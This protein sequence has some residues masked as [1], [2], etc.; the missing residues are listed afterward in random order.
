M[1]AYGDLSD[2]QILETDPSPPPDVTVSE[3]GSLPSDGASPQET[4]AAAPS[5]ET[6][7]TEPQ[8]QQESQEAIE[9][10]ETQEA[11]KTIPQEKPQT[12]AEEDLS[13]AAPIL[14]NPELGPKFKQF[15]EHLKTYETTFG[16]VANARAIQQFGGVEAVKQLKAVGEG[17]VSVDRVYYGS[18]LAAKQEYLAGIQR[19]NP[20]AFSSAVFTG[21][22][23]LKQ[24]NPEYY[25]YLT[26]PLVAE[27]LEREFAWEFLEELNKDAEKCGDH[28]TINVLNNLAGI[29]HSKY[30]L[31]PNLP[32]VPEAAERRA[33]FHAEVGRVVGEQ[34]DAG[35]AQCISRELPNVP[36]ETK[37]ALVTQAHAGL[38]SLVRGNK[39][40]LFAL[41]NSFRRAPSGKL[42]N[43]MVDLLVSNL[44]P[45][46]PRIVSL[47][48]K[49]HLPKPAPAK[50]KSKSE[51][52]QSE[53]RLPKPDLSALTGRQI[54]DLPENT[55]AAARAV[56]K[57]MVM[58][59]TQMKQSRSDFRK[60]LDNSITVAGE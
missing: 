33:T 57:G 42:G 24:S 25:E 32:E 28:N 14:N 20:R 56:P 58:T 13:W 29:F 15:Q 43:R 40:L 21:L 18:D 50:S 6:Q 52:R 12:T 30:G 5:P 34:L 41:S 35:I 4:D 37:A 36:L 17:I 9:R 19:Q 54:L 55:V 22:N 8:E 44:W 26:A 10:E 3:Q 38:M 49:E 7:E 47:L 48:A 31:G 11:P 16:S 53:R 1:D 23:I 60:L 2:L 46:I 45:A 59:K 39:H 51:T 27:V